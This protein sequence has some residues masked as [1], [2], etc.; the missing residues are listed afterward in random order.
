MATGSE[1]E[2]LNNN[3]LLI[4]MEKQYVTVKEDRDALFKAK[5]ILAKDL[6]TRQ[7]AIRALKTEMSAMVGVKVSFE[8]Q[9]A[10]LTSK[11]T[12]V[13][14]QLRYMTERSDR[15]A[16]ENDLLREEISKLQKSNG[17]LTAQLH[18]AK[19]SASANTSNTLKFECERYK[20][21]CQALTEHSAF[22]EG[23]VKNLRSKLATALSEHQHRVLDLESKVH[24][25]ND[26]TFKLQ[27]DAIASLS[28]VDNYKEFVSTLQA[29]IV[30]RDADITSLT[31]RCESEA[32]DHTN[33]RWLYQH[34]YELLEGRLKESDEHLKAVRAEAAVSVTMAERERLEFDTNLSTL[35]AKVADQAKLIENKSANRNALAFNL[36]PDSG[37]VGVKMTEVYD[38]LMEKEEELRHEKSER[39]KLEMTLSRLVKEMEAKAPIIARRQ[40]DYIYLEKRFQT[41]KGDHEEA[42]EVGLFI[43]LIE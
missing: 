13:S 17:A 26:L 23:E 30:E 22:L 5:Q 29:K 34:K 25:S 36:I 31:A 11:L 9:S 8:S 20:T 24:T 4:Q 42:L 27:A 38:S 28:R 33:L 16:T 1:S 39:K 21:E 35:Q 3:A 43:G 41:L 6:E 12:S 14:D 18:T 15:N 19:V 40:R 32:S 7:D 37:E 10:T 2:D